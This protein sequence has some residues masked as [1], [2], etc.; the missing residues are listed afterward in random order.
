MAYP[1]QYRSNAERQAA[2]RKRHQRERPPREDRLAALARS[3]HVVFEQAVQ[4]GECVLPVALLGR[5]ADETLRN[6]VRYVDPHP[7]PVRYG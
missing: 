3:L 7:D 2:Y 4:E 1:R 6:L 5:Q